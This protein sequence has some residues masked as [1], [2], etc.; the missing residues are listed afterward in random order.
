M[1]SYT[2]VKQAVSLIVFSNKPKYLPCFQH[3]G[4][5]TLT[6]VGKNDSPIPMIIKFLL[7]LG[8][9]YE[10]CEVCGAS[11]LHSDAWVKF[12]ILKDTNNT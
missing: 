3:R 10:L 7:G 9:G 8:T 4:E 6:S 2:S 1:I 5:W 11:D 12:M